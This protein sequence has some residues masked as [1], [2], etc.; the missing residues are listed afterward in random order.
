MAE[1]VVITAATFSFGAVAIG[2][3]FFPQRIQRH[4]ITVSENQTY[5]P[6]R[7]YIRSNGYVWFTRLAGIGALVVAVVSL[8]HLL[9]IL[10]RW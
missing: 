7:D 8:H 5:N 9:K 1:I 10:V 6:W 4:A 2:C 3:L